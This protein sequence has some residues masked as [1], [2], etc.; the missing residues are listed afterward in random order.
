MEGEEAGVSKG[1]RKSA[2]L[3]QE[4]ERGQHIREGDVGDETGVTFER[5]G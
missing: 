4:A 1:G 3:S 2:A 5:Q